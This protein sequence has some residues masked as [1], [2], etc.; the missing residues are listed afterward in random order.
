MTL[1]LAYLAIF[2]SGGASGD[3]S[4]IEAGFCGLT[5]RYKLSIGS[6]QKT[7]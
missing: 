7:A 2:F 5:I 6:H 3:Y 4:F 1:S